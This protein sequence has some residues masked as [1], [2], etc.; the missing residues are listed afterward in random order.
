M[1]RE[2]YRE[3]VPNILT[4]GEKIA[5]H[6]YVLTVYK[7]LGSKRT[8][9]GSRRETAGYVCLFGFLTSSSTTRP[10]RIRETETA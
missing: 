3:S 4:L 10:Y 9:C 1:R 5:A 8:N 2:V 7:A 6:K